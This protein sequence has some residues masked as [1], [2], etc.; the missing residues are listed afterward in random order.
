[1]TTIRGLIG[2]VLVLACFGVAVAKLPP[3]PP[4][5]DAQKAA[6]EEKKA[7]DAVAAE[8]AKQVQRR[9]EDRVAARYYAEMR[10]KG[11]RWRAAADGPQCRTQLGRVIEAGEAG[12]AL[13]A[14]D[15]ALAAIHDRRNG[16]GRARRP[17]R[18]VRPDSLGQEVVTSLARGLPSLTD[19]STDC[20][21]TMSGGLIR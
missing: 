14:G 15:Q 7:K 11:K 10:A 3:A 9:A 19:A 8:A 5:T 1:M 13:A 17:L 18:F 2:A 20:N 4:L 12:R 16:T 6:A 21:A